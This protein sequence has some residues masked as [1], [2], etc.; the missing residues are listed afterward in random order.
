M[1]D[2]KILLGVT[3]T[4]VSATG[5]SLSVTEIQAIVLLNSNAQ[6]ANKFLNIFFSVF[7]S[8]NFL[9][10]FW[11]HL[12]WSYDCS[13]ILFTFSFLCKYEWFLN[14]QNS[15]KQVFQFFWIYVLTILSNDNILLSANLS[16]S[17]PFRF[18]YFSA[19]FA[20]FVIILAQFRA[21]VSILG[22]QSFAISAH[23]IL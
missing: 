20:V 7:S 21:F 2:N 3:G 23:L 17:F 10:N 16:F 18:L 14:K 11:V 12:N 1:I 22:I 9:K 8:Q 5:A 6:S 19:L 15:W 4:A 13:I